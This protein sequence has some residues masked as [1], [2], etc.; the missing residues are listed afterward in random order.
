MKIAE[1]IGSFMFT[2]MERD[3]PLDTFTDGLWIDA[4]DHVTVHADGTMVFRFLN[5]SEDKV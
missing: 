1:R 5:G 4:M 2:L 3:Q